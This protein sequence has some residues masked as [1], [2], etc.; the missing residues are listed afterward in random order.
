M[1]DIQGGKKNIENSI[2]AIFYSIKFI[3]I[4]MVADITNQG[5]I[6]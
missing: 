4:A 6:K 5:K 2:N 3:K 1:A